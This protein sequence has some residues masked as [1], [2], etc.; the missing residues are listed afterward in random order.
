MLG[1]FWTILISRTHLETGSFSPVEL[2][3]QMGCE[4]LIFDQMRTCKKKR[5]VKRTAAFKH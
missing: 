4:V 3:M 1:T 5:K 2:K